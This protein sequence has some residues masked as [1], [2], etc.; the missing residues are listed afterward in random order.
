MQFK[1]GTTSTLSDTNKYAYRCFVDSLPVRYS[2]SA[3]LFRC[4][5]DILVMCR[6]LTSSAS[7]NWAWCTAGHT[8]CDNYTEVLRT[9][10]CFSETPRQLWHG[11]ELQHWLWDEITDSCRRIEIHGIIPAF[12][13]ACHFLS[14]DTDRQAIVLLRIPVIRFVIQVYIEYIK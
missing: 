8:L 1:S 6:L 14:S 11:L 9:P 13:A 10:L 3:Y 2:F 4:I 12:M 7:S 5:A